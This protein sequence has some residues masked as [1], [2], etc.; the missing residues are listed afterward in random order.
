[1]MEQIEQGFPPYEGISKYDDC[2]GLWWPDWDTK[3]V[4]NYNYI[5][6]RLPTM[7]YAISLVKDKH[8]CIQAGGHAG[9]WP[10]N[11]MDHFKVVITFEPE[12][13][14]FECL[15]RNIVSAG[16][17]Q[18]ISMYPHA[19]SAS[20]D[21]V[22]LKRSGSSG[23]N[24]VVK[25]GG[26]L[27]ESMTIDS[28]KLSRLDALFLDV[29]HHEAQAIEGALSTIKRCKPII[30]VEELTKEDQDGVW[31]HLKLLGYTMGIKQGKDRIYTP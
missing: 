30:Q 26:C 15:K 6:E 7:D 18:S 13:D 14:L 8:I 25:E 29:E 31:S 21:T 16:V 4:N 19:L 10:I 12:L 1:M 5:I 24:R 2:G 20:N 17:K 22:Q 27:V 28:L 23:S 11:L 9:L 3:R